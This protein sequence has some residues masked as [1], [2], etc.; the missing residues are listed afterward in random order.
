MKLELHVH[1]HH[2]DGRDAEREILAEITNLKGAIMATQAEQTAQLQSISDA[3]DT[4]SASLTDVSAQLDKGIAEVTAEI[5]ALKD[6]AS[7][8][9]TP[10]MDAL[11]SSIGS[12]LTALAGTTASIKTATQALDDMNPD[13]PPAP[14]PEPAPSPEL[15]PAEQP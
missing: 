7:G 12:K 11:F 13:A 4:A 10:E 1:V 8:N 15:P 2:H 5:A 14:A 6:A 9:S 3:L